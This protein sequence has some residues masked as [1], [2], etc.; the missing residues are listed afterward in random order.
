MTEVAQNKAQQHGS[1]AKRH[2]KEPPVCP[3]D[4]EAVMP[5]PKSQ[6]RSWDYVW[7]SGVAGGLAGCAVS[8]FFRTLQN[9]IFEDSLLTCIGLSIGQNPRRAA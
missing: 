9:I 7:R 8:L 6:T 4:D 3:T 2:K 1:V 5:K